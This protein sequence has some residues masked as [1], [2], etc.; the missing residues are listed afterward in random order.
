[1]WPTEEPDEMSCGMFDGVVL[2]QHQGDAG[3]VWE[4]PALQSLQEKSITD[5]VNISVFL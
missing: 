4:R 5:S 2:A 3:D 1:M